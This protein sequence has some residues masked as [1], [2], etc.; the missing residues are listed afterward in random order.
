M[1]FVAKVV[2]KYTEFS[3]FNSFTFPEPVKTYN[4]DFVN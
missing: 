1:L 2:R 4:T 3:N